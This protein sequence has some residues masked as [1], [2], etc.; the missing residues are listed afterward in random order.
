MCK[1][2]VSK[3]NSL[4]YLSVNK[5]RYL[6]HINAFYELYRTYIKAM[7]KNY[8]II[9]KHKIKN[10]ELSYTYIEIDLFNDTLLPFG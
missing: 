7:S 10:K 1:L 3:S 4:N 5:I 2:Y 9:H 6:K 8:K